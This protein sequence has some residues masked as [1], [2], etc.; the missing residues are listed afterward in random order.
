VKIYAPNYYNE[1]KCIADKCK[2]SCCIGWEIDIDEDTYD[3]YKSVPGEFGKRLSDN[4]SHSDDPHF[5][6]SCNDRCPFLNERGLCDIILNIGEDCLCDICSDH[7][8]FRNFYSDRVE[9]GLGLCCEAAGEIILS[10]KEPLSLLVI[11][12][13]DEIPFSLSPEEEEFFKIREKVFEITSSTL[14]NDEKASSLLRFAGISIPDY[15]YKEWVNFF[16]S[17]ENLDK[18]WHNIL[19][20]LTSPAE[21]IDDPIFN[22]AM[23]RL[24]EYFLYRHLPDG[25]YDG[26]IHARIG[27]AVLG[28]KIISQLSK[29]QCTKCGS[30]SLSDIVEISRMYSSEIEYSDENVDAILELF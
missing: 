16:K 4:I 10:R 25:I 2:H 14:D 18:S 5:I 28:Y 17:L 12:D 13:D 3:F 30:I 7:P 21:G 19:D 6:L 9:L 29:V 15:S 11:G 23:A 1:F 24:L 20:T 8:R 26:T 22:T 27:F